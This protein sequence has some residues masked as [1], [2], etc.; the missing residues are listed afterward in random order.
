MF[1]IKKRAVLVADT[2][3]V[4]SLTFCINNDNCQ[5]ETQRKAAEKSFDQRA[6][7]QNLRRTFLFQQ[8]YNVLRKEHYR[9]E[10]MS[11]S[12][13]HINCFFVLFCHIRQK[14]YNYLFYLESSFWP[15]DESTSS[16]H[17]SSVIAAPSPG[18]NIWPL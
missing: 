14:R 15:P 18:G 1:L 16:I 7:K 12:I 2:H 5:E 6:K 3:A 11:A 4:L 13:F 8:R 10:I 17:S 9:A